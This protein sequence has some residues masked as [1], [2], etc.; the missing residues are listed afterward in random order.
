MDHLI[1]VVEA[2]ADAS[3]ESRAAAASLLGVQ[4][5]DGVG[6]SVAVEVVHPGTLERSLGKAKRVVDERT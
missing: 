5:K 6:V 4:V 3:N 1:V 2:K